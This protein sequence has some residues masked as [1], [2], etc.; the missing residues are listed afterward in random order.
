MSMIG[1]EKLKEAL[2]RDARHRA[3]LWLEDKTRADKEQ[4]LLNKELTSFLLENS[5]PGNGIALFAGR[6]AE[7]RLEQT[8]RTLYEAQRVIYLPRVLSKVKAGAR[9]GFGE[10]VPQEGSFTDWNLEIQSWGIAEP[11]LANVSVEAGDAKGKLDWIVLPC[12]L[13]D[14]DGYRI[15]HGGGYY[16]RFTASLKEQGSQCRLVLPLLSWQAWPER[17]PRD[18]WDVLAD[19]VVRPSTDP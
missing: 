13:C 16:D 19:Y 4:E 11:P 6:G 18:P 9:M 15:G 2:R 7:L 12:L 17:L 14:P 5:E 8:A 1:N 3:S 10:V